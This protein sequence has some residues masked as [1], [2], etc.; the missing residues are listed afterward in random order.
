SRVRRSTSRAGRRCTDMKGVVFN[1][2]LAVS[3]VDL[4]LPAVGPTDVV[5][6]VEA[7]GVCGSDLASYAHGHYV[8]PGQVM[9]HEMS[10][11]VVERGTGLADLAIGQR[12]AVRPM[13]SCDV[14][15]YCLAGDTHLCGSTY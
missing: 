5:L 9:G 10:A 2:P 13:R 7:C 4:E 3:T 14:C 12:V 6:G 1:G 8:E 15:A 11:V